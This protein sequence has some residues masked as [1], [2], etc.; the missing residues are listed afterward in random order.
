VY[1][2][3]QTS[4][5][6]SRQRRIITFF[7]AS[8]QS[9]GTDDPILGHSVK[10]TSNLN[11]AQKLRICGFVPP[12]ALIAGRFTSSPECRNLGR[13]V[14]VATLYYTAASNICESSS[15]RNGTE[16]FSL[17]A[18]FVENLFSSKPDLQPANVLCAQGLTVFTSSDALLGMK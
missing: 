11:L 15:H 17:S 5:F 13:Q 8:G 10:I 2:P 1:H 4:G 3:A 7:Q 9:S 18:R 6:G 12:R 14:A 16:N